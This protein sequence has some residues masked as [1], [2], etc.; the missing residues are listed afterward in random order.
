[1]YRSAFILG[2][3]EGIEPL[4][5]NEKKTRKKLLSIEDRGETDRVT[6]NATDYSDLLTL[7]STVTLTR[8]LDK[9]A[10]SIHM[11]EFKT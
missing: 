2:I 4:T 10:C 3:Y 7:T 1:M 9:W 6:M 5:P 11:Q 8:D